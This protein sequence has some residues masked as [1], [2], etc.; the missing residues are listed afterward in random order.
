MHHA[1]IRRA[2]EDLLLCEK[3]VSD[4]NLGGYVLVSQSTSSFINNDSSFRG[5]AGD[6]KCLVAHRL[7]HYLLATP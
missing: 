4:R 1:A 7:K 6:C 2:T 5:V 3:C